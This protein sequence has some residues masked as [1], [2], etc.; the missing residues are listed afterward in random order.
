MSIKVGVRARD[1][2]RLS[3]LLGGLGYDV[4]PG[5]PAV[6]VADLDRALPPDA[7]RPLVLLTDEPARDS[8]AAAVLP[9]AASPAQIDAAIR[10]VLAGLTVR[11]RAPAARGFGEDS[12][13]RGLLTPRELEILNAIGEGLSNKE[14]AR[15]LDISAHTVKFHLEAVFAKLDARTRSEAV[16]KGLRSGLIE[17]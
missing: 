12:S 3:R 4:G 10:A 1:P 16:A 17:L 11:A 14:V 15:R 13:P 5:D 9:R 2:H 7:R 6:L 8:D